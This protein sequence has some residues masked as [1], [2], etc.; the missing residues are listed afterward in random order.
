VPRAL[1]AAHADAHTGQE[2]RL[3]ARVAAKAPEVVRGLRHR[4]LEALGRVVDPEAAV[5]KP[6]PQRR[7][8]RERRHDH[9]RAWPRR[10]RLGRHQADLTDR[11]PEPRVAQPS[12]SDTGRGRT[13]GRLAL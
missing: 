6:R 12:G 8:A 9:A 10:A 4:G 11:L 7:R 2:P 3:L 5:E 13:G 1:D